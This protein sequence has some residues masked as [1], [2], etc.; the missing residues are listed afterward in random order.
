[1]SDF[2]NYLDDVFILNIDDINNENDET[3]QKT[4]SLWTYVDCK[5]P[6]HPGV[7]VCKRC[8]F[9]FSIKSSNTTF[10]CYLLNKHNITIPKV[11]K[12]TTLKFKCTDPWPEKEKLE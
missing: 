1:M 12:Q 10:E 8:N 11:R 6:A 7:P 5:N 2:L 9:V 4:S 3:S